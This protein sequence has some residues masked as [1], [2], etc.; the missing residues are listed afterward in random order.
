MHDQSASEHTSQLIS[1]LSA[2]RAAI[3]AVTERELNGLA[4][5]V[6][7]APPDLAPRLFAYLA[8]ACDHERARRTRCPLPLRALQ[9]AIPHDQPRVKTDERPLTAL[10]LDDA[11]WPFSEMR[12]C[13][14]RWCTTGSKSCTRRL[15]G[16]CSIR[17]D[18]VRRSTLITTYSEILCGV[19]RRF[20]LDIQAWCCATQHIR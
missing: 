6:D 7:H 4:Q 18:I 10:C 1:D 8:H 19:L 3:S 9:K 12:D 5:A 16:S 20:A 13:P 17:S 11:L 2:I 15:N 14:L